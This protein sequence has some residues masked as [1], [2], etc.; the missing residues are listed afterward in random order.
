MSDGSRDVIIVGGGIA[1]GALAILL[2]RSGID[3]LVLEKQAAYR[4]RVRGEYLAPWGAA[5]AARN[6]LLDTLLEV[7][8][9]SV[10]RYK[11]PYDEVYDPAEA[12]A[13]RHDMTRL[14][15]EAPGALDLSHPATC[16]RLVESAAAAGAEVVRDVSDLTVTANGRMAVR[17]VA[18]AR[19]VERA[20]RL[21][22]GADGRASTVRHQL[23][24]PLHQAPARTYGA[25][26][27]V[28]GVVRWP[29]DTCAVGTEGD[30]NFYVYPRH[31]TAARLYLFHD[32]RQG[33]RFTGARAAAEFLEAFRFACLP[34]SEEFVAARPIGPCA[35]FPMNDAWVDSAVI[36]DGAV[37]VGDAAGY[38]DP[39]IGQGLSLALRDACQLAALLV[40][41]GDWS[42][43][44]LRSYAEARTERLRRLRFVAALVTDLRGTFGPE[45]RR[46]RRRAYDL[47]EADPSSRL[48]VSAT[49]VGPERL[50]SS[51][52][53]EAAAARILG[54]AI[55]EAAGNG[56]FTRG[57]G[58]G[59][60]RDVGVPI[61]IG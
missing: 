28:D 46:R 32:A 5:D 9:T 44:G 20:C 51:A 14:H 55:R 22:V 21:L 58:R 56:A 24:V 26:L 13:R 19:Q 38:S 6:G 60:C 30:L 17:Y 1:G 25:G 42:A 12:Q 59:R 57:G 35:S 29:T 45:Q 8:H 37:L 34:G 31:G 52:F 54:P 15:A 16:E 47:F 43:A 18:D 10:V 33:R 41:S 23:E 40:S 27:L 3:V 2:A 11:T 48:P 36:A 7:E 39:I 53:D 49:A 61:G 50:P 4:D